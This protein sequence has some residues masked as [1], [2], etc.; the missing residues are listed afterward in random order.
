MC[1]PFLIRLWNMYQKEVGC[2]EVELKKKELILEGLDCANCSLKI[3][4]EMN[5]LEGVKAEVNFATKTLTLIYGAHE[6]KELLKKAEHIVHRH[7]PDVVVKEKRKG[8]TEEEI[9]LL[10]GLGCANCAMKMEQELSKL[11]A[12]KSVM[13]DFATRKLRVLPKEGMLSLEDRKKMAE[14]I[15]SIEK[16]TKLILAEK[17]ERKVE[18]EYQKILRVHGKDLSMIVLSGFLLLAA[19]AMPV[20]DTLKVLLFLLSYVLVGGEIVLRAVRNLVRGQVF[21]ENFLMAIATI[22]AFII[23][24]Y[25]EGVAVMLFYQVGEL[26]QSMAVERSRRSIAELMDIRPEYANLIVDGAAVKV[27]PEEVKPGDVILVKPG[28]KVPL[29]GVV[30]EGTSSLNTSALTGESMPRDV[31]SGSEILS[32]FI[33]QNGLLKVEVTKEFGASAVSKILE[34]VENASGKKAP[35]ESFISKFA[36]YYTPFVV[37]SALLLAVIPPL[38]LGD[39]F[40]MWAYRALVFLVISCPCALVVSIP[41]GFFGGIGGASR[42]GVLIKGG[43]YL[44]ALNDVET[45]V[46]DKTGTLTEGKFTVTKILPEGDLS[47]ASLLETAA[48]VESFS[49]HP[50]SLSIVTAYGKE[51]ERERISSYEEIAGHGIKAV[52]DGKTVFA[53]NRRLMDKEGIIVPPLSFG[54]TLVYLSQG[55]Q[56]IGA[57]L[58]SDTIK[59]GAQE[60]IKALKQMGIRKTVM[61]TGDLKQVGEEIGTALSIDEVYTELLPQDKV[62]VF[63]RLKKNTARKIVFVG[64]GINDAPVLAQADI[65]ISMGSLGSDAAIEASDVV[66]MTDEPMRIVTALKIAQ[67]TRSIVWQ[68]IIFALGV[69]GV[70][71]VL[72]AFGVASMW[73]A[74][75][76]DVGVTVI[77]VLNA[78]RVMKTEHL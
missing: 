77:A 62:S 7:E 55:G 57:L 16:D 31:E 50:I 73:E 28:E 41:L 35:T 53:G 14:I 70:F 36:R 46:F 20:S 40:S 34:L 60:T 72:G 43:N 23:G 78:M 8:K 17:E 19:V 39:P 58:I 10:E 47:E 21:D 32:G 67:R 1:A 22:G 51:L 48:H 54:G 75:F 24:E 65:G 6:D 33:N 71:L 30:V 52:F 29:D 9:Y 37:V 74:V 26:F 3:E 25:A 38:V 49:S 76:A 2:D 12:V 66:L 56:Y 69:K 45:V 11:P 18:G 61:L 63:E 42:R 5:T 64:D 4:N 44:E 15:E 59:K 68:N 13:L 27:S